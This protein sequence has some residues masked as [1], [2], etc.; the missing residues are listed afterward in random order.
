M[1]RRGQI[2]T[3][4][5]V[6]MG[7]L[8]PGHVALAQQVSG[9]LKVW[10]KVTM[11]FAGPSSSEKATPNPFLDYRLNVMFTKGSKTYVVIFIA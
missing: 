1:R 5:S 4:V 3:V 9:E 2:Q 6:L 7:I 8:L 11:T 10:H